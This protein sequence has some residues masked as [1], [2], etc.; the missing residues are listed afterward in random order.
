MES[1]GETGIRRFL[2][3]GIDPGD[4]IFLLRRL[5]L[6]STML[7][8]VILVFASFTLYNII[9]GNIQLAMLDSIGLLISVFAMGV[10]HFRKKPELVIDI[11]AVTLFVF[12]IVFVITNQ[13]KSYGLTWTIL[14]PIFVILLKGRNKGAMYAAI[15]FCILFPMAYMG[16]GEWQDGAWDF[17]SFLRYAVIAML[18]VHATYFAESSYQRSYNELNSIRE[19]ERQYIEELKKLSDTDALTMLYNRRH[20]ENNYNN[21]VRGA[22]RYEQTLVFLVLDIDHFKSY[23]D[24]YGHQMGDTALTQIATLIQ[25]YAKRGND[26]VFRLGGEEFAGVFYCQDEKGIKKNIEAMKQAVEDLKI[27]HKGSD[28]SP[29]I[30][31]S[32]GVVAMN[33]SHTLEQAYEMADRAL[34][35]AKKSG[36]NR[37]IFADT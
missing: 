5:I 3:A 28:L 17:T 34:Y 1:R 35:Q 12:L 29:Y 36:R 2:L 37:V 6:L 23:N 7:S 25:S 21:L 10:L 13:N 15:Y 32:I 33:E 16:I 30:T 4:D 20:L 11:V 8:A 27:E 9:I 31:V 18:V 24:I 14:Y 26:K 22:I 19:R